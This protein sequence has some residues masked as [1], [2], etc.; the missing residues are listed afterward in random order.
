MRYNETPGLG[1]FKEEIQTLIKVQVKR[2]E[3]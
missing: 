2:H 1:Y 3:I